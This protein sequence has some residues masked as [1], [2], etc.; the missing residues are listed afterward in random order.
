[1]SARRKSNPS[2]PGE[3]AASR[4]SPTLSRVERWTLA[5]AILAILLSL[6]GFGWGEWK[7]YS[8]RG[9][10]ERKRVYLSYR[11][12]VGIGTAVSGPRIQ[13]AVAGQLPEQATRRAM[14]LLLANVQGLIDQLDLR[15]SAKDFRSPTELFV[16]SEEL[17]SRIGVV[18]S[19]DAE[20]AYRLGRLLGEAHE[21]A[22]VSK[23]YDEARAIGDSNDA[24]EQLN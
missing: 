19:A 18:H 17:A 13:K 21:L 22:F 2:G 7:D 23:K 8:R 10:E 5:L 24:Q 4:S 9:A 1:M 11:L 20:T 6:G 15:V 3:G 14:D 12:G 16:I